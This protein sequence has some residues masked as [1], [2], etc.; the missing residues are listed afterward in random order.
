MAVERLLAAFQRAAS[1]MPAY[2]CLLHEHGVDPVAIVDADAF[3]A[4]CPILTK[5][6]T[7]D[8]FSIAELCVEG[9]M[10]DLA[11]VLTSS[12]HGGGFRSASAPGNSMPRRRP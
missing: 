9:A 2:R 12:G 3:A 4:R 7:F 1:N 5:A 6:N 10:C 8:R 11:N